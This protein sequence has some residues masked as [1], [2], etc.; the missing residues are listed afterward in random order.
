MSTELTW[1]GHGSWSIATGGQH[2]VLDPFFD[3]N[4]SSTIKAESVAADFILISHGHYDHIADAKRVA[5][6]TGALVVANYEICEWLS[7]QGVER[8]HAMN[9]G[10]GHDF[11]FGR[12]KMTMAQHSSML[13][14][15]SYGGQ[16]G[17][18][19][20]MLPEGNVY[21]ACD[22]GLFFDMN[23]IGSIGIDLAVLPIGDNFTMG[24]DDAIHAVGLIEPRRVVPVHLNTWPVI[25]QDADTWA[26]RVHEETDAEPI[27]LEP[28]ETITL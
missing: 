18:F 4:P 28:G 26:D 3:D 19:V 27:V 23:V 14:D 5:D 21:F 20:L 9:I 6:R 17:G 15:G 24:P 16:S 2:V 8:T 1:L 22:T 25:T 12:V 13:P 7:A 11:P 10:G